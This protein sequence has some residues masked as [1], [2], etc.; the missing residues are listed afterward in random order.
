MRHERRWLHS[1]DTWGLILN[2]VG[3]GL[4]AASGL[5]GFAS[6]WGGGIVWEPRWWRGI[7]YI[8]WILFLAGFTMQLWARR[9]Q[10]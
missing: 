8:G 7:H 4:L 5:Y 1:K 3:G 10:A 6:G 9:D 2:L